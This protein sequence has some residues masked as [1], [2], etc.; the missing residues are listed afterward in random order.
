MSNKSFVAF[1][2]LAG[3]V[4]AA[5]SWLAVIVYYAMVPVPQRQ[6]V[7][8]AGAYLTSLAQHPTGTLLFQGLYALIGL[9]ALVGIAAV[10]YRVRAVGE[11]WAVFATVTG[12]VA[13]ALTVV[14]GIYQVANLRYLASLV[15]T[16]SQSIAGTL[17]GAPVPVNPLGIATFALT[18]VWFLV[19]ALLMLRTDLPRLLAILGFVAFADLLAGFL[20]SLAG[21]TLVSNGAG[22]IAGAVGGP[23]FWLWLGVLLYRGAWKA[24]GDVRV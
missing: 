8:D 23:V 7:A 13:A 6:P 17:F 5:G 2:G 22:I 24:E 15:R 18:G 9:C 10:Y 4:L 11:A 20:A 14:A 21:A 16:P 3:I 12:A 19:I 1:G